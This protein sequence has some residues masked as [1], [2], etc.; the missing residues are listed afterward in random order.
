MI[1]ILTKDIIGG[2]QLYNIFVLHINE[3]RVQMKTILE[4]GEENV[5]YKV[6]VTMVGRLRKF[7]NWN[8]LKRQKFLIFVRVGVY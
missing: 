3:K 6:L 7:V 2:R 8:R 1:L 4:A 5:Y